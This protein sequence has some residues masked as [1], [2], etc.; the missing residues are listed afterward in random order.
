MAYPPPAATMSRCRL[1][2]SASRKLAF[3]SFGALQPARQPIL[4]EEVLERV[5]SVASRIYQSAF[6]DLDAEEVQTLNDL[7][8]RVFSNL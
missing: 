3:E 8:R 2:E 6:K 4:G 5:R 1:I 7:L